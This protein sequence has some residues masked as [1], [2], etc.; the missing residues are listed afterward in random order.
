MVRCGIQCNVVGMVSCFLIFG[1]RW[2]G[3][4]DTSVDGDLK[5]HAVFQDCEFVWRTVDDFEPS[6]GFESELRLGDVFV[7]FVL[8]LCFSGWSEY[9]DGIAIMEYGDV[10][11]RSVGVFI[12]QIAGFLG[13]AVSFIENCC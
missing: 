10:L 1:H 12:V 11:D 9:E 7:F 5:S 2:L 6:Y 8:V 4:F 13:A 3:I